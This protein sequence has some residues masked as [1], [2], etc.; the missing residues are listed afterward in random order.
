M[1]FMMFLNDGKENILFAFEME[2]ERPFGQFGGTGYI[3]GCGPR[4]PLA[5]ENSGGRF[6]KLGSPFF[7][8]HFTTLSHKII[9]LLYTDR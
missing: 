6:K 1:I 7:G 8:R 3:F 9:L 2:I 4:I 5:T